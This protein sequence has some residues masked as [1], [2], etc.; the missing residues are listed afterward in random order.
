MLLTNTLYVDN[1]FEFSVKSV[2]VIVFFIIFVFS[3]LESTSVV[4]AIYFGET[5]DVVY[6]TPNIINTASINIISIFL[7]HI[8]LKNVFKS[9]SS[10][11]FF[12]SFF[13]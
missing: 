7:F 11:L 3:E 1:N 10:I 4:D 8:V 12:S 13:F 5:N 2:V 6:V 9:I